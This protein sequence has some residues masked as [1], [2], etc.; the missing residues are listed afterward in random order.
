MLNLSSRGDG[1]K[2]WIVDTGASN[3]VT[4]NTQNVF[5]LRP[6]PQGIENVIKGY[7]TTFPVKAVGSLTLRSV[8]PVS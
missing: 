7:G 2:K 5:D 6:P 1:R 8:T 4:G 3:H